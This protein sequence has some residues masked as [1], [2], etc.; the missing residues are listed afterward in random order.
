MKRK[1]GSKLARW[2]DEQDEILR[3]CGSL[4]VEYCVREIHR[5]CGVIRSA[6]A[7][8]RHAS[9]IGASLL[10]YTI[11]PRCGKPVKQ[12]NKQTGLCRVCNERE[13]TER[14]E[15]FNTTIRREIRELNDEREYQDAKRNHARIRK[16][17]SRLC[18]A[19]GIKT[20]RER[21]AD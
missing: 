18:R 14:Q 6:E 17:N 1:R 9:R 19:Y 8:K 13:R 11:C 10:V 3:T 7:T 16:E 5:Q 20:M 4:G 12:A 2:S 15:A 21:E